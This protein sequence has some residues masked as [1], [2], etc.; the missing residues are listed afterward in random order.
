MPVMGS[1]ILRQARPSLPVCSHSQ[2]RYHELAELDCGELVLLVKLC[3]FVDSPLG[4]QRCT[5]LFVRFRQSC[6]SPSVVDVE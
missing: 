2:R 1:G 5:I 6:P 3:H 4:N